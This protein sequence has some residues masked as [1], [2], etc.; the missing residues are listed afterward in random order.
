MRWT[1]WPEHRDSGP[2][3]QIRFLLHWDRDHFWLGA[4][5]GAAKRGRY[6]ETCYFCSSMSSL[7]KSAGASWGFPGSPDVV[8]VDAQPGAHVDW[9][10]LA[11][12]EKRRLPD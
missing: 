6:L 1:S 4:T 8:A 5:F 9:S 7:W 12:E 11:D 3:V 2:D 10:N